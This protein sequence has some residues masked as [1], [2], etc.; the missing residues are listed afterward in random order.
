MVRPGIHDPA[1][2][3]IH[4]KCFLTMAGAFV[5]FIQFSWLQVPMFQPPA[6]KFSKLIDELYQP[7]WYPMCPLG[8]V[9]HQTTL[10]SLMLVPLP[11]N[12]SPLGRAP[13]E[14]RVT[15]SQFMTLGRGS[16]VGRAHSRGAAVDGAAVVD[17]QR[18]IYRYNQLFTNSWWCWLSTMMFVGDI[19]DDTRVDTTSWRR[20]WW[21][22]NGYSDL[23]LNNWL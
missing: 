7:W 19:S 1:A 13:G 18:L 9:I 21:M 23:L 5:I 6:M 8:K 16:R 12:L 14:E 22:V 17:V 15:P 11:M 3:S 2:G 10:D 4:G 20:L